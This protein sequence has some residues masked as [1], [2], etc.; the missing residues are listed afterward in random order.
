MRMR[1][2]VCTCACVHNMPVTYF[3]ALRMLPELTEGLERGVNTEDLRVEKK[4]NNNQSMF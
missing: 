3:S 1:M 4:R 2:C